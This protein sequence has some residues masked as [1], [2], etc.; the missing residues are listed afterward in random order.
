MNIVMNGNYDFIEIQGTGEHGSF[1][2]DQLNGM[3]ETAR[4]GISEII[5]IQNRY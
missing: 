3:L 5:E 4:S 1:S 2:Y